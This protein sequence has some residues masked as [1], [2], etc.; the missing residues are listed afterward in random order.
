MWECITFQKGMFG[1]LIIH[2]V[3]GSTFLALIV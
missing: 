2:D 1:M 3:I